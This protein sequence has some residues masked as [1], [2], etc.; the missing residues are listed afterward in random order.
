[1]SSYGFK[2]YIVE[3]TPFGKPSE[4]LPLDLPEFGEGGALGLVERLLHK[5]AEHQHSDEQTGTYTEVREVWP[6]HNGLW[7]VASGGDYG[8]TR[9]TR[10]TVT[11]EEGPVVGSNL[12]V[13]SPR[14]L[15]LVLP[16][17]G[18]RGVLISE[19]KGRSH[20]TKGFVTSLN[21]VLRL[22][23]GGYTLRLKSDVAD[24]IAW[25]NFIQNEQSGI[26]GLQLTDRGV[27][28]NNNPLARGEGV[29]EIELSLAIE[30]TSSTALGLI[31][32]L[33]GAFA[34]D[35]DDGPD[36]RSLRLAR[37]VSIPGYDDRD[38]DEER[39]VVVENGRRRTINVSR[40]LPS[41]VYPIDTDKEPSNKLF[42]VEAHYVAADLF[43]SLE[44]DLPHTWWPQMPD[45]D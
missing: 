44:I 31:D 25:S 41:F 9:E 20:L 22:T 35:S 40:G 39:V 5:K 27:G 38:F 28:A 8:T 1:M 13:L 37:S 18:T 6:K 14:R 17:T 32:R 21:R 4:P 30:P 26:V 11:G 24:G 7:V 10:D 29:R 34:N 23:G 15:V 42:G 19:V 12:A 36:L 33:R 3:I 45:E 2:S 43:N 16:P